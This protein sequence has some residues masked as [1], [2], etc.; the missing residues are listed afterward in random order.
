MR[1]LNAKWIR[2]DFNSDPAAIWAGADTV[3]RRGLTEIRYLESL[4]RLMEALIERF[5]DMIIGAAPD[6]KSLA[7]L[8]TFL[9]NLWEPEKFRLAPRWTEFKSY[10]EV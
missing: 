6:K 5:P 8:R 10:L 2:F 9:R 3:D 1:Q 7:T 4:C